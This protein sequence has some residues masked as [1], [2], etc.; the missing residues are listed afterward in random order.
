MRVVSL[1]DG[2]SC[3]QLAL[4]KLGI[5]PTYFASEIDKY[6]MQVSKANYPDIVQLGS[7][8]DWTKW[9]IKWHEIDLVTG[10]FPCQAWSIAGKQQG[11]KDERGMLFWT[12]LDI[13]G[14]AKSRNPGIKFLIEN[15][16]MKKE[17]EEY[18][19]KHT[20]AALGKVDKASINSDLFACQNRP[21]YY[22]TNI[23][24]NELPI[25]PEWNTQF[26]QWRRTFFRENKSGVCPCL[27]ANMGT[28]GH[29]VPLKSKDLGDKLT[30]IEVER[31]QTV[32]DNYTNHVSNSQ[33][34]K[35]LGNGW[36]IDVI[37][38]IFKGLKEIRKKTDDNL[39]DNLL[40][41]G[42]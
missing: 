36:T 13:I 3:G 28:G 5:K 29:N 23:Y 11:D 41:F 10:G 40:Y 25:R 37:A 9:D 33:R 42:M 1:F 34:Y 15:V 32:P 20:E 17:F 27:T 21:R 16:K 12:M 7:V 4:D 19:T 8:T 22:W 35:M 18:I 31:L 39:I 30:P 14:F 24:I 38:H 2:M 26:Y 6:A